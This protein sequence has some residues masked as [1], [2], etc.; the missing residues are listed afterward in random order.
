MRCFSLAVGR[1]RAPTRSATRAPRPSGCE[2]WRP[3]RDALWAVLDRHSRRVPAWPS[4]A[5]AT[6]TTCRC[7]VWR[8]ASLRVDLIDLDARAAR[9]ARG[10]LPG[11]LRRRVAVVRE[12]VTAGIADELVSDGRARRPAG[13]AGGAARR[14]SARAPTTSSSA[15]C[16]TASCSIPPC[17]T[18]RCRASASASCWSASIARSW[19][20]SC[21]GCTP[22]SSAA[23]PSCTCTTHWAGGTSTCSR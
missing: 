13:G 7:A 10:R 4:W 15:T 18:R 9:G 5:P 20:P 12:D 17:A 14:R 16:S 23:G 8:S 22:A 2:R 1:P 3:A 19:P 21:G 6:G 11:D